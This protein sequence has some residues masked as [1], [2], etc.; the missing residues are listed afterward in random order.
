MKKQVINPIPAAK[1][2]P[3]QI[4]YACYFTRRSAIEQFVPEHILTYQLAGKLTTRTLQNQ[5]VFTA[6]DIRFT[7]RNGLIRFVKEPPENGSFKAIAIYLDQDTLR[8]ISLE[9]G[10]Q[11]AKHVPDHTPLKLNAHPLLT[12]YRDFLLPYEDRQ[13]QLHPGLLALKVREAVLILLQ[14]NPELKDVLFDFSEPGKIDLEAFMLQNYRFNVGL[15]RFAY[16]TGRSLATFK[17][18]FEKIFHLPPSRWLLQRRLQDA[19]Y[20][21]KEQ[22]K[23]ASQ[24]YLELGFENLSHFSYAFKK[25]YG[26]APSTL[27]AQG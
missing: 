7:P 12:S 3:S 25:A 21:L 26:V 2:A 16:L 27:S 22:G 14:T 10:Y 9:Y 8:S 24:V 19:H 18:D 1:N 11:A 20:L 13:E 4:L 5:Q 6:G 23:A 17:R 15:N